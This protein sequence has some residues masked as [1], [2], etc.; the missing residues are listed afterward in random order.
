MNKK[1]LLL[2]IL[3]S[4]YTFGQETAKIEIDN[5]APRVGQKVTMS[6]SLDFFTEYVKNELGDNIELTKENSIHGIQS[7]GFDRVIIFQE[8]KKYKVG[9]FEFE[10]NG[11]KH[12]T[13]SIDINVFPELP[14]ESGLWLRLTEFNGQKYLILEQLISNVSNKKD[15]END[16]G[17]SHTIGGVKPDGIE[18][19][20]IKEQL[21]DELE[22]SNYS[23]S[24]YGLRPDDAGLFDVGFSYS[25]KKYKVKFNENFKNKYILTLEDIINLPENHQIGE[26]IL[27]N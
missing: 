22:L 26:I 6:I 8:A 15:N 21:T 1:I 12:K 5:P 4:I 9:P 17:Y 7:R 11:K 27:E 3:C 25:I 18:F 24:S 23:S 20:E 10:F 16:S 19:A 13:N 14:F 2:L